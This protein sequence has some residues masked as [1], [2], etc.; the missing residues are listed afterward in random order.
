VPRVKPVLQTIPADMF[1]PAAN[2]GMLASPVQ[3]Q[4]DAPTRQNFPPKSRR[5]NF[6]EQ[7]RSKQVVA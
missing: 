3:A 4:E 5:Q 2:R 7:N 1:M 6:S